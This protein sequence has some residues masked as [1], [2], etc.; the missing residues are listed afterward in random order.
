MNKTKIFIAV[1]LVAFLCTDNWNVYASGKNKSNEL[2]SIR[3][4]ESFMKRNPD[5]IM[6][7]PGAA[8]QKWFYEQGVMLETMKQMFLYTGE[9][10]YFNYIKNNIDKLVQDN[11]SIKTYRVDE[12]NID[13]ITPGR[14]VLYLYQVTGDKKYKIA[15]D[16][17][18]HQLAFHPRTKS[19]GFWHKQ[20][21]PNQMWL[22]GLYM[23]EPF[24]S[25]YSREFDRV[26]DFDD[27]AHQFELMY[28]KARD[29][30]T[31]LLYHAWDESKEQKWADPQTGLSPHFWGRSIGW[32]VMALVDVLDTFPKDHPKRQMLIEQLK[33]VCDALMKFRDKKSNVWYQVVDQG[34]RKGN[35]LEAS[36]SAMYVYA[37]AKGY[38]KGYLNKKYLLDAQLSFAGIL[39]QF[40]TI[41]KDGLINL[42]HVCSVAGLGGKP[43]RDGSFEYYVSEKQ[44]TNDFKG[45][46]PFLLAA[47]EIEKAQKYAGSGVKVGL[48]NY[49]NN[50]TRKNKKTGKEEK[51]HYIIADTTNSG[52]AD[53][54]AIFK[55]DGAKISEIKSAPT[56]KILKPYSIYI[57]VDPD[58]PQETANP[59]YIEEKDI[60]AITDWVKNGGVLILF[61]NDKGN[62]EFEHL[63]NLAKQFGWHFNEV[64]LNRV[65]G[66]K[67][68]MGAFVKLP[69]HPIFDSVNKIYMKEIST[70]TVDAPQHIILKKDNDAAIAFKKFGKGAVLAIG[71]PWLYNEYIAHRKLPADFENMKAAQNL[72]KW[73]LDLVYVIRHSN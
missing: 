56:A 13:Q 11:G 19:N 54:A 48:D 73:L 50:E 17:L 28:E 34:K 49:F 32:Y 36:A 30:K 22:D 12:F 64:S 37:F 5:V 31:G 1:L 15:V 70:I 63:N 41:D 57:I 33:N 60:T 65:E 58:T 9:D 18:R 47:I 3:I 72:V 2:W 24:Y 39:K 43:Y 38:N 21:Y 40:V 27:I 55:K 69:L 45:Y 10:K 25:E 42:N 51:F 66:N 26:K 61:A 7:E 53:F 16:T 46:G 23:G 14:A 8:E 67:Y 20:I 6:Y 59:N 71:D 29:P 68:D 44:R 35:Y 52:F 62:S 4:A